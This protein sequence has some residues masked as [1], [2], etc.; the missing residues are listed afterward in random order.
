MIAMV[1]SVV[2]NCLLLDDKFHA[3]S[4]KH[5]RIKP[6][7]F[8]HIVCDITFYLSELKFFPMEE[9]SYPLYSVYSCLHP[10]PHRYRFV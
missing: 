5:C 9:V 2:I 6:N 4:Y 8:K 10:F 3:R 1:S 7:I